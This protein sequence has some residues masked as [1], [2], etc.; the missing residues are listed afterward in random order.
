MNRE[1]LFEATE[2][3]RAKIVHS[4]RWVQWRAI[5]KLVLTAEEYLQVKQK[6][7]ESTNEASMPVGKR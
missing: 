4:L 2:I 5:Q 1:A 7:L 6:K 3:F